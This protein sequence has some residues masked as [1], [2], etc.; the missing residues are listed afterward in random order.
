MRI[1]ND[2]VNELW[3][4]RI[5]ILHVRNPDWIFTTFFMPLII[6]I[7]PFSMSGFRKQIISGLLMGYICFL[8]CSVISY[9]LLNSIKKNRYKGKYDYQKTILIYSM[10]DLFILMLTGM[11]FWITGVLSIDSSGLIL[12]LLLCQL[13][14]FILASFTSPWFLIL[15]IRLSSQPKKYNKYLL[16]AMAI[17]SLLPSFGVFASAVF[18]NGVHIA[19]SINLSAIIGI[20]IGSILIYLS[21]VGICEIIII[22]LRKWP[23][24]NRTNSHYSIS[25]V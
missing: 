25:S 22:G 16:I 6:M 2:Q 12:E 19:S 21:T 1:T 4:Q 3:K 7:L 23:Q 14:V 20:G 15:K 8:V 24:I 5:P 17:A 18:S 13:L 10:Y 11:I 9:G